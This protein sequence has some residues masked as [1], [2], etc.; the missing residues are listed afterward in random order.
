MV[1]IK[2]GQ[3]FNVWVGKALC[4]C[5]SFKFSTK[6]KTRSTDSKVQCNQLPMECTMKDEIV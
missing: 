5:I 6:K 4:F 3:K 1:S 2:R